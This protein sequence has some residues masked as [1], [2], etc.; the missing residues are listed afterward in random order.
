MKYINLNPFPKASTTDEIYT[1]N[2]Y[3][4]LHTMAD[5]VMTTYNTENRTALLVWRY[6]GSWGISEDNTLKD[7]IDYRKK[8]DIEDGQRYIALI[9]NNIIKYSM[10][11]RDPDMPFSEDNCLS[12]ILT[13]DMEDNFNEDI[14]VFEFHS[15]LTIKIEAEEVIFDRD[16]ILE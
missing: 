14:L 12:Q 16:Y 11:S 5:F 9:F 3:Y 6:P 13:Y 1:E 15:G 7:R 2:H 10:Q 4:D 8:N